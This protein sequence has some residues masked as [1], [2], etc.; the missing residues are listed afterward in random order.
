MLSGS[1]A[2]AAVHMREER[3]PTERKRIAHKESGAPRKE[4][5]MKPRGQLMI[6]HRLIEKLLF[7]VTPTD[8]LTYGVVSVVLLEPVPAMTGTRPFT[9]LMV[10]STTR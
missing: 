1:W 3:M 5:M 2:K 8:G 9:A 7:E 6:E 10:N 4:G